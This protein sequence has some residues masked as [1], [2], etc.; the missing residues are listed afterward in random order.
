MHSTLSHDT[1]HARDVM[2]ARKD[3]TCLGNAA[4]AA[5][6]AYG[7]SLGLTRRAYVPMLYGQI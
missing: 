5:A 1:A 3:R 2:G 6:G 7:L 4:G